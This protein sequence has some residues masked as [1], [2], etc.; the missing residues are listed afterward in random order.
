MTSSTTNIEDLPTLVNPP[1]SQFAEASIFNDKGDGQVSAHGYPVDVWIFDIL[2]EAMINQL[3]TFVGS[4]QSAEV[5]MVTRVPPDASN[6]TERWVKYK[7][8]MIWP[9]RDL[10]QKRRAGGRYLG[11]EIQFRRLEAV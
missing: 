11:V 5:Y 10:M 6:T 2:D 7:A 8:V 3:R 9:S 1:R 4:G